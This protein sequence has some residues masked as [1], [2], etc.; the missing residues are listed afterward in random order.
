MAPELTVEISDLL[1]QG[2]NRLSSFL[3]YSCNINVLLI[4]NNFEVI[5][6]ET[7]VQNLL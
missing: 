2:V 6:N 7:G 4:L 1:T 3:K 5:E